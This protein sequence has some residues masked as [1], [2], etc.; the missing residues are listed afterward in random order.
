NLDRLV[1]ASAR[2]PEV[3]R[4]DVA[5]VLL[6]TGSETEERALREEVAKVGQRALIRLPGYRQGRDLRAVYAEATA[7]V[8]PSLCESF[9][10]A[11][12][13]GAAGPAGGGGGGVGGPR[14]GPRGG[15][16]GGPGPKGRAPAAPAADADLI[17]RR[18]QE[19][20]ERISH[21]GH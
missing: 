9:G 4:G 7:L 10:L 18:V 19:V 5:L 17:P 2:L 13:R 6:G 16:G 8:F 12:R 21:S 20:C 3:A 11:G 14:L 15:G 1:R